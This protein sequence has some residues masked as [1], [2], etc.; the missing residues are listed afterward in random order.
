MNT[1]QTPLPAAASSVNPLPPPKLG[2]R[3]LPGL[4]SWTV[5]A[6]IV[7]VGFGDFF[8]GGSRVQVKGMQI[9]CLAQ[10]KQ[11]GLALRIFADDHDGNYPRAGLPDMLGAEVK[12]S[13]AAFAALFPTYFQNEN[14]FANKLSAYQTRQP[15]N[16]IDNPYTGKPIRTLEPGENVYSYVA[17]LTIKADASA[18][19]VVDGTDGTGHYT[20]D[21]KKRGGLWGGTK[22]I[23]IRLDNSGSLENLRG[24]AR[25]RYIPRDQHAV[26]ADSTEPGRPSENLL[27]LSNLGPDVRLLDPAVDHR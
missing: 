18:P 11:I 24:P 25:A 1:E 21:P 9:K 16:Q 6:I 26:A 13:N 10:A 7:I 15:D 5:I 8:S 2:H 4:L 19:L 27:D 22:A 17:G 14:I 12:D 3:H 23:V 20:T